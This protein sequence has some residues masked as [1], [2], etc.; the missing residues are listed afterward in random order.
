[1]DTVPVDLAPLHGTK[2]LDEDES[3][4]RVNPEGLV[5]SLI[6]QEGISKSLAT[7]LVTNYIIYKKLKRCDRD[8]IDEFLKRLPKQV[9]IKKIPYFDE[10]IYDI[11]GLKRV[12]HALFPSSQGSTCQRQQV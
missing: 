9:F 4:G 1:M 6:T 11:G 12:A 10:E 8:Q 2:S 7:A 5:E 3:L